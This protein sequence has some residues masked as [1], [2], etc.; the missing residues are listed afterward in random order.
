MSITNEITTRFIEAYEYLL[1]IKKVSGLSDFSKKIEI[2][3]SMMTEI[4]KRRSNVGIQAIQNTEI[5]FNLNSDWF[6]TGR[7][8]I[9]ESN[10]NQILPTTK[11]IPLIPIEAM[12]GFGS[13]SWQIMHVEVDRYIIPEF[14]ELKVD[15]MIKVKGDSMYPKYNSG[16][17]VACKNLNLADVFFQWNKVYVLDTEQGALIKRIKEGKNEDHLLIVSENNNYQPFDLHKSKINAISI[18]VGVVRVE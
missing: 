1:S 15:Y 5:T 18:V 17:I 12:A 11:S 8:E 6:I 4:T 7:G 2:S 13:G 9:L 16:D 10:A 14:A 3:T